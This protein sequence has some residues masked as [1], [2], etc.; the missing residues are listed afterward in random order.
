MVDYGT[1]CISRVCRWLSISSWCRGMR[2]DSSEYDEDEEDRAAADDGSSDEENP[3]LLL[4][5]SF[6]EDKAPP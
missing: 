1:T 3:L 5:V 6:S 4:S 2:G